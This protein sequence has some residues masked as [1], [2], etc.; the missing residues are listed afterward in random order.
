[1]MRKI[2][3]YVITIV[4]FP[5]H[6]Y[7]PNHVRDEDYEDDSD[8]NGNNEDDNIRDNVIIIVILM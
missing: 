1:M 6:F 5:L 2:K 4:V 8:H 3:N 7:D